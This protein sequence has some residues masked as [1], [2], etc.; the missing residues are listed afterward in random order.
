MS[1]N[2][3]P[4]DQ[5]LLLLLETQDH[6]YASEMDGE[7]RVVLFR[8]SGMQ[9]RACEAKGWLIRVAYESAPHELV[10]E[11]CTPEEAAALV[12]ALMARQTL[13]R[14]PKPT[15]LSDEGTYEVPEQ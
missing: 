6:P 15:A 13:C 14:V 9:A 7:R 10:E 2:F 8:R 1:S 5:M 3:G 4:L 12:D 11:Y